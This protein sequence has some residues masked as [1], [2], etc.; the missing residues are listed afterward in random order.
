MRLLTRGAL[1]I[2]PLA[3]AL[4]GPASAADPHMT[5]KV[6]APAEAHPDETIAVRYVIRNQ[7][8]RAQRNV[9]LSLTVPDQEN[10]VSLNC[11]ALGRPMGDDVPACTYASLPAGMR[12]QATARFQICCLGGDTRIINAADISGTGIF[13]S[14]VTSI[15]RGQAS[16]RPPATGGAA[17]GISIPGLTIRIG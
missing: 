7:E 5:L 16:S 8:P 3:L 4:A 11:G 15:T 9:V 13:A 6:G 17:L 10:L 1:A 2:V 12:V 14:A